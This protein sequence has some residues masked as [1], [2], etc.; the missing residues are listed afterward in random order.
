MEFVKALKNAVGI[1]K[2]EKKIIRQVA[3]D[4]E[5]MNYGILIIVLSGFVTAI[6]MR[7]WPLLFVAPILSLVSSFVSI[8]FLHILS[9]VFGGRAKFVELF[10][11]L[12]HAYVLNWAYILGFNEI[13]RM[14]I[15][16]V[17]F[18]WGIAV[19][20]VVI[21]KVHNL[22]KA[23]TVG[24]LVTAILISMFLFG[25]LLVFLLFSKVLSPSKFI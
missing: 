5:S 17:V 14:L 6:S 18:V 11:V 15:G 12:S 22:S 13:L 20:F 23:K 7:K 25:L 8:G 16:L 3:K 24:V 1:I 21:E 9:R 10:R 4:K 19:N 2:L